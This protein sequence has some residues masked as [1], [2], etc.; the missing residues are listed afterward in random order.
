[1]DYEG[2]AKPESVAKINYYKQLNEQG[3]QKRMRIKHGD[4]AKEKHSVG[5]DAEGGIKMI[6]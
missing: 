3:M 2:Q 4:L 1:M 6:S 5:P